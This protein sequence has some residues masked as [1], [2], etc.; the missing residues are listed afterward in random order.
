MALLTF[1]HW[2]YADGVRGS[3]NLVLILCRIIRLSEI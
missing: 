3:N 1:E 2:F